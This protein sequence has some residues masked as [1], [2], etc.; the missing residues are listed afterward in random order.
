[1]LDRISLIHHVGTFEHVDAGLNIQL[2]K[3]T[4][5]YGENGRGKTTLG[6]ILRSVATGNPKFIQ[7][8]QRLPTEK[9][10]QVVLVDSNNS[11]A[12]FVNG[13]WSKEWPNI[14]LFD[15]NFI[16]ENI[17]SGIEVSHS[18]RERLHDLIIGE[19]GVSL[20]RKVKEYE[21]DIE[22][23]NGA[24]RLKGAALPAS[25]RG[26]LT[27]DQFCELE[28]HINIEQALQET[29]RNLA[30]AN[31]V[32][33]IQLEKPFEKIEIP[34]LNLEDIQLLLKSGLAELEISSIK[35]LQSHLVSLG[36]EGEGW[37]EK[38]L[39]YID[40]VFKDT[41]HQN[42]PFCVQDISNSSIILHYKGNY[43]TPLRELRLS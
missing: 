26:E 5:I 27:V 24:L 12:V 31:A 7:D 17:Y 35:S 40:P 14:V 33:E 1:M 30:A 43:S 38:G 36:A 25:I 39:N 18:H 28:K 32:N 37:V 8:R 23:H 4:L 3:L 15:D 20:N 2:N 42:C 13:K 9:S 19:Q 6:S 34:N 21:G 29:E 16:A 41:N 11:E 22:K 10:P